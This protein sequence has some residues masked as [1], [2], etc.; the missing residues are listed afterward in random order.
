MAQ[1]QMQLQG[2][3]TDFESLQ[4]GSQPEDPSWLRDLRSSAM[5]RFKDLGLPTARRGNEEWKYT[6]IAP[7]AR[8]PFQRSIPDAE[9]RISSSDLKS[10]TFGEEG[11]SQLVFLDGIFRGDLSYV[12]NLPE[13]VQVTRLA[14]AML[15]EEALVQEHLAHYAEYETK[16]LT[17]LNTAFLHD[18]AF[19]RVPDEISIEDPIHLLFLTTDLKEKVVSYPRILILIG[20]HSKATV[21]ESYGGVG[22]NVYFTN[23]VAEILLE[24]SSTLNYYKVQRQAANAYHIM[25]TQVTLGR[26]SHFSSVNVDLGGSLVRNNLNVITA[27]E[28][29][30][31]MLNGVYLI[32]GSQ[33][34]DNQVII[35]HAKPHTVSRE[36]YKGVLGGK[37]RSVFHGSII[38]REGAIKVDAKQEDKNLLL[39][40]QAEADTKPA[41]W[42]YCDD[43]K[44]MHGAACGQINENALFYLRS[45]GIDEQDA[46]N[47]LTRSFVV[48]LIES[49]ENETFRSHIDKLAMAKLEGL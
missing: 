5:D 14:D 29:A 10:F 28:G 4:Q 21:I 23:A 39:S 8:I 49:I 37:S 9:S 44:C 45:R 43:V 7:L 47:L 30:S 19:V 12:H 6:N 40:N 2:Y 26:D 22:S 38:V 34:I 17:A 11:W 18:G 33:H 41:F 48:E 13:G 20:R 1:Q 24:D 25:T 27:D 35:D 46:R 3:I 36:L 42:I 15:G 32:T 31:C 16:A